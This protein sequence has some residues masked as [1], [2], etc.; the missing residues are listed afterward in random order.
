MR[1]QT[2]TYGTTCAIRM[3]IWRIEDPPATVQGTR[4]SHAI[5]I[6]SIKLKLF[7]DQVDPTPTT[8]RREVRVFR[9]YSYGLHALRFRSL[10]VSLRESITHPWDSASRVSIENTGNRYVCARWA[11]TK[12]PRSDNR[13]LDK[14][15]ALKES[16]APYR[17]VVEFVWLPRELNRRMFTSRCDF[18]R[19]GCYLLIYLL[20]Y[21][22]RYVTYGRENV[23]R[24]CLCVCVCVCVCCTYTHTRIFTMQKIEIASLEI[25]S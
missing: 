2:A 4:S 25:A 10:S 12:T 13:H 9:S 3:E 11:A 15:A 19:L 23:R 21:R 5:D 18:R 8:W 1:N 16:C 6:F 17:V 14:R 24:A 22:V 20:I 7:D